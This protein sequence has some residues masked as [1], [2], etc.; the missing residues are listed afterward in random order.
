M[1]C[2]LAVLMAEKDPQLSQRKLAESLGISPTTVNKLYNGRPLVSVIKP[3][4]VEK[5]CSFFKCGISDLFV[6]QEEPSDRTQSGDDQQ[7]SE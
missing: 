5:V 7:P 2:K 6:L 3:D 4:V 1:H